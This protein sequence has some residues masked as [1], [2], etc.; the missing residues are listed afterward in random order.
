MPITVSA[1]I[2]AVGNEGAHHFGV[3]FKEIPGEEKGTFHIM[4]L[5]CRN[6]GFSTIG[7]VVGSEHEAQPFLSR[8]GLLNA[9]M[10]IDR[11]P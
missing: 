5:Q 1:H 2:V 9:S 11:S 10:T 4:L 8:V 6:D 3:M 7:M